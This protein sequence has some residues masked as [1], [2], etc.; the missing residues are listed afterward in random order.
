[1][2]DKLF[3]RNGAVGLLQSIVPQAQ[4]GDGTLNGTPFDRQDF[5]EEFADALVV[6]DL[7]ALTSDGSV[8]VTVTV[9]ESDTEGSGYTQV[10]DTN[11]IDEISMVFTAAGIAYRSIRLNK[12]KRFVRAVAVLDFTAGTTPQM[13]IAVSIIGINPRWNPIENN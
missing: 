3:V 9:E 2:S 8:S 1:M 5:S 4:V 11:L 10:T 13:P 7:G 6:S 12:L